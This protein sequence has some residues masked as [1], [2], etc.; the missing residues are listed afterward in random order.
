VREGILRELRRLQNEEVSTKELDRDKNYLIGSY[1]IARQ[2]NASKAGE[3]ASNELFGFGPDFGQRYQ[4]GIQ[5]V[6]AADIVKFA[7]EHLP[8]DRYVLAIVGP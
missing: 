1:Q 5:K 3:L 8:L 7:R 2:S 6:S 4:A